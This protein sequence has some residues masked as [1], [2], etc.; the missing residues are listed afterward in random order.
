MVGVVKYSRALKSALSQEWIKEL[1]WFLHPDIDAIIFSL[2][3]DLT[4]YLWLLNAWSLLQLY[5]LGTLLS[6]LSPKTVN[7]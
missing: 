1:S 6:L 3:A 4:L 5:L 7:V 2:T